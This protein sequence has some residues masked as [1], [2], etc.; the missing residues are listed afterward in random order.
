MQ[1]VIEHAQAYSDYLLGKGT[2]PD[3]DTTYENCIPR[4]FARS[5]VRYGRM[6]AIALNHDD[7]AIFNKFRLKLLHHI[8]NYNEEFDTEDGYSVLDT[9]WQ[10]G[11]NS[12]RKET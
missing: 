7:P 1:T 12:L 10:I 2:Y 3:A 6:A 11:Y 4:H 5:A 9:A 8:Q